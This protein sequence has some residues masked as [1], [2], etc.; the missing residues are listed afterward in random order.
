VTIPF[1]PNPVTRWSLPVAG[2]VASCNARFVPMGV[3][4][5][6]FRD[7]SLLMSRIFSNDQEAMAW[8]EGQRIQTVERASVIEATKQ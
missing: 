5:R 4:V 1:D 6:I 3:E 8:A 2:K 7:N